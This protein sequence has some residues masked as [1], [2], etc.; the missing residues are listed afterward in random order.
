[1]TESSSQP[2]RIDLA[3]A[4][5]RRDVVHRAVACLAQGGLVGLS[6]ETVYGVAASALQP[7]AV[8]RLRQIKG[9]DEPAPLTL[10]LKGPVEVADWVPGLSALGWR[11]ARRAWPG[12]ITLIFPDADS[13]GLALRL[14]ASVRPLIFPD[15][16]VALRAP[17]QPFIREILRLLP[18]PLVI[19]RGVGPDGRVATTVNDLDDITGLSLILDDGPTRLGNVSTSVSVEGDHYRV[20]RPGV[21]DASYLTRM[22][23]T[24]LMFI[25]TGNTCRSPM[26]EA[27]CKVLLSQRLG[28]A[29]NDL[30]ERGFVVLS[31]GIA[32]S[33]GMPAAAHAV[34]VVRAR[35]GSLQHHA[36]R[37]LTPDMIRHAD[38]L[39]T[40][41]NDH[42]EALLDQV[43]ECA[44]HA[45]LLHPH[46]DDV[47]DPVG[48]DRETYQRTARMIEAYLVQ[49]LDDLGL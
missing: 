22:A 32:T 31:A 9:F 16:A 40:M 20:V 2:E 12:P 38:Y 27:L 30:E 43:P 36:S 29:I 39:V 42:L 15:G 1:M 21:V 24:I 17:A 44:P 35:G 33:N 18:A 26:A 6:T 3:Q 7:D 11:L 28:C 14:P 45:R 10:L 19:T 5:D 47:A 8:A 4:D 49:L 41:T 34:E 48:A 37:Q 23:G 13:R 25:C 46:G